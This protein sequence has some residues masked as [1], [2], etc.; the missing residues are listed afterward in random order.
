MSVYQCHLVMSSFM[1]VAIAA[2]LRSKDPPRRWEPVSLT[3]NHRIL[4]WA[5]NGTPL[6]S[7]DAD[8][9]MGTSND[10]LHDKHIM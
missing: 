5:I 6:G 10:P 2:S 8:F 1:C 3:F 9:P 4:P 7:A